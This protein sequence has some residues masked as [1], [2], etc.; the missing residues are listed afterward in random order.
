MKKILNVE[1]NERIDIPD[2]RFLSKEGTTDHLTEFLNQFICDP[3]GDNKFIL[4]GF[5]PQNLTGQ[6]L[7]ISSGKALLGQRIDGQILTTIVTVAPEDKIID[8]STYPD[9]TYGI[10]IRFEHIKGEPEG[11]IF[12]NPVSNS[13]YTRTIET[14]FV[15]EWSIRIEIGNPGG[16][17]LKIGQVIKPSMAITDLR[18]FFFEGKVENDYLSGWSSEGGG[19]VLDRSD[20][21]AD[22]GIG[23][24]HTFLAAMRQCLED[25]KGRGLRRWWQKSIGG[26]NIGFSS[27]PVE[28]RF[29]IGDS[30]FYLKLIDA[31]ARIYFAVNVSLTYSRST[32][33]FY[34]TDV[35]G[36][37]LLTISNSA[38]YPNNLDLGTVDNHWDALFVDD[39]NIYGPRKISCCEDDTDPKPGEYVSDEI[40]LISG[41]Y[42]FS[43]SG[44]SGA[45]ISRVTDK[46]LGYALSARNQLIEG[47]QV[48]TNIAHTSSTQSQP[49]SNSI[50][51]GP[52]VA[53]VGGRK[54]FM[55]GPHL[56]SDLWDNTPLGGLTTE[57]KSFISGASSGADNCMVMYMW[58]R[59]DGTFWAE[60]FGPEFKEGFPWSYGSGTDA[61]MQPRPSSGLPQ[62]G[63]TKADYL[64]I[65][66]FWLVYGR[67]KSAVNEEDIV[68]FSGYLHLGN[69]YRAIERS[70]YNDGSSYPV[71]LWSYTNTEVE[72]GTI[73]ALLQNSNET[74]DKY[75]RNPGIPSCLSRKAR[76][77]ILG[78]VTTADTEGVTLQIG[79]SK[80]DTGP[81]PDL[82]VVKYGAYSAASYSYQYT[83]SSGGEHIDLITEIRDVEVDYYYK[84]SGVYDSYFPCFCDVSGSP[85]INLNIQALGFYWNRLDLPQLSFSH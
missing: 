3:D 31:L 9:N 77:A 24:L 84:M 70:S 55:G 85:T 33:E 13:E 23:D 17:W 5:K 58:L 61:R 53:Y 81:N 57:A 14:R 75:R 66:V 79:L 15:P 27:E 10:Y 1:S 19:G 28:G 72:A 68:S 74:S 56:L 63:F 18:H 16:E 73:N 76:V 20:N 41:S 82:P 2:F 26:M 78:Q 71:E 40:K 25:I 21:R 46:Y 7:T 69:G 54:I 30:G 80:G 44:N 6:Q 32:Q 29:A 38:L 34:F 11:R 36:S 47:F 49:L 37:R 50:Y 35:T 4:E 8:M 48:I 39:V 64:L 62:L 67:T 45:Y 22:L 65:D 12:W 59:I 60:P 43:P 51:V 52:G 42:L 83:N